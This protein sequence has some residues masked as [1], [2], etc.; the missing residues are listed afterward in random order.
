[1]IFITCGCKL[2]CMLLLQIILGEL[3]EGHSHTLLIICVFGGLCVCVL[4]GR[5]LLFSQG[6]LPL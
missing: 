2:F 5:G 1:M 6:Y 4:G 3:S